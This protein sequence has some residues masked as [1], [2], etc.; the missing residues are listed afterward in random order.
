MR[1]PHEGRDAGKAR[2]VHAGEGQVGAGGRHRA[3]ASRWS[4]HGR[5]VALQR[6]AV[7]VA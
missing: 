5:R 1:Q 2:Q 6:G 7:K 4:D 3:G